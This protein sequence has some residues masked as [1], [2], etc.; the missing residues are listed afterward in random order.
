[1]PTYDYLDRRTGRTVELVKSILD[2]DNVPPYLQR[3][4]VPVKLRFDEKLPDPT[5]A[6]IAAA[7]GIRDLE[8]KHGADFVHRELGFNNQQLRKTWDF[9]STYRS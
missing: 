2:R 9:Q 8:A 4:V 3:L 1:M 6:D 7:K 5:D